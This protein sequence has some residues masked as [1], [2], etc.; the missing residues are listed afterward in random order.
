MR[1]WTLEILGLFICKYFSD[2]MTQGPIFTNCKEER[3]LYGLLFINSLTLI[4]C[5][6]FESWPS[7]LNICI[8]CCPGGLGAGEGGGGVLYCD[9]ACISGCGCYVVWLI[10]GHSPNCGVFYV[11]MYWQGRI[12]KDAKTLWRGAIFVGFSTLWVGRNRWIFNYY[13]L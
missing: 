10:L 2:N 5:Y 8:M 9:V 4:M 7:A 3:C 13:S 12:Q 11:Y 6:K 1:V